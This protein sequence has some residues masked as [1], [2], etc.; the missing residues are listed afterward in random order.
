MYSII[1]KNKYLVYKKAFSDL[2]W[3][4]VVNPFRIGTYFLQ[5]ATCLVEQCKQFSA[6][7]HPDIEQF[8]LQ[9]YQDVSYEQW[10]NQSR[11]YVK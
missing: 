2:L 4:C 3:L 9:H 10:E 11:R 8:F 7:L 1:Y 6:K 5:V